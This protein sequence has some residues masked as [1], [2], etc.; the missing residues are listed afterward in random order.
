MFVLTCILGT[1]VFGYIGYLFRVR[2]FFFLLAC[3]IGGMNLYFLI[4]EHYNNKFQRGNILKHIGS[5]GVSDTKY[6]N[7]VHLRMGDKLYRN[8]VIVS[9]NK[10]NKTGS[11]V[12][13]GD[14]TDS[15]IENYNSRNNILHCGL[16]NECDDFIIDLT[17][18][19]RNCVYHFN[20]RDERSKLYYFI[21]YICKKYNQELNNGWKISVVQNDDHF[22]ER[23][24]RLDEFVDMYYVDITETK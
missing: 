18:D 16:L 6:A 9:D 4:R 5:I 13:L 21:E 3:V 2:V 11:N 10:F 12:N 19:F 17:G 23:T 24:Y 8:L 14:I 7:V 1:V 22:T 20:K 15:V